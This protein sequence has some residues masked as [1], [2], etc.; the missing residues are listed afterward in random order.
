MSF[1]T[2]LRCTRCGTHYPLSYYDR[3]CPEC[4]DVAPS[5][6]AVEYDPAMLVT[7]PAR[8]NGAGL[9]RYGDLLPIAASDAV[10]L[11]EGGTPLLSLPRIAARL[12]LTHLRA[13]DE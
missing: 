2:G 6:L 10:S 13:K 11:G 4:H 9:W 8:P 7:R 3:D 1:A 5:A 12:G